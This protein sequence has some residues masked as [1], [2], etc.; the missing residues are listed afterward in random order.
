MVATADAGG[1]SFRPMGMK[2]N[3]YCSDCDEFMFECD[4]KLVDLII[5]M[6]KNGF[7]TLYC[8]EGHYN[9]ED[10]KSIL[11]NDYFDTF[12]MPYIY[13]Y[14]KDDDEDTYIDD[15]KKLIESDPEYKK[16]IFV[17]TGL[18]EDIDENE[19]YYYT[20]ATIRSKIY[21]VTGKAIW[22]CSD[23]LENAIA[24]EDFNKSQEVFLKFV[25]EFIH[26]H[27]FDDWKQ[28]KE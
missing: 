5:A 20:T 15:I 1:I 22:G 4:E 16:Y 7:I 3:T 25:S 9:S 21:D 27:N 17:Q 12:S 13:F 10:G 24:V 18:I 23:L 14:R 26:R 11:F 6:N 28:V 2:Y 8:C 19:T